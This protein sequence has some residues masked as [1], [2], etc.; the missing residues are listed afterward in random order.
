MLL[1][2]NV[3]RKKRK[4]KGLTIGA[5]FTRIKVPQYM[6]TVHLLGLLQISD[7]KHLF[8]PIFLEN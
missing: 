4:K 5:Y 2:F 3:K 6:Q 8:L 1:F 7:A